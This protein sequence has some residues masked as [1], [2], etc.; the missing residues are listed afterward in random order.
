MVSDFNNEDFKEFL[1]ECS[2]RLETARLNLIIS[3]LE[4]ELLQVKIIEEVKSSEKPYD[5]NP[6]KP[7]DGIDV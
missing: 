7:I 2:N 5:L 3:E 6:K 1:F 4:E